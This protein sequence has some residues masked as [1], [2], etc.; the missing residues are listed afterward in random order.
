[1]P[2]VSPTNGSPVVVGSSAGS[3][4][5]TYATLAADAGS[6]LIGYARAEAGAASQAVE[7]KLREFWSVEDFGAV[8]DGVTDDL[9]AFNEAIA[10]MTAAG[11]HGVGGAYTRGRTLM[12]GAKN[13]L[14]SGTLHITRP[15]TLQG[16][17]GDDRF[18]AAVLSFPANTK[19][20][21][22]HDDHTLVDNEVSASWA[23]LRN[24]AI[25]GSAS[26]TVGTVNTSGLTVTWVSGT[27]FNV[28]T[29]PTHWG[30]LITILIG[31]ATYVVDEIADDEELTVHPWRTVVTATNNSAT[32][33]TGSAAPFQ[34]AW[35]GA[36][37]TINGEAHTIS[38][39]AVD[40]LSLTLN[41][42]YAEETTSE[43]QFILLGI[44]TQTGAVYRANVYHGVQS[45]VSCRLDGV[46]VTGFGGN[47]FH[48]D[49]EA[50]GLASQDTNAN[51]FAVHRS[52]AYFCH[53]HGFFARGVNSNNGTVTGCDFSNNKGAGVWEEGFL[54]N[55]YVG[56]HTAYNAQGAYIAPSVLG[57]NT[58]LSC[59]SE[60]GQPASRFGQNSQIM[61]GDHGAGIST[62]TEGLVLQ[63]GN[64]PHAADVSAIRF[65]RTL[66]ATRIGEDDGANTVAGFLGAN[67]DAKTAFGLSS[68]DESGWPTP[69][70]RLNYGWIATGWWSWIHNLQST[71]VPFMMS[72]EAADVGAGYLAIPFGFYLG[73]DT[74]RRFWGVGTAAPVAGAHIVGDIVWN[75]DPVAGGSAGWM[76]T[77]AGTP[78]DWEPFGGTLVLPVEANT[79]GV[80]APNVLLA[81]EVRK[82]LTNEGT[83]A[84]NY[85]TLPTAV[86]GLEYSFVVQDADGIRVTAAAG[87]TIRIAASVSGTAGHIDSTTIGDSV[88]LVAINDTEWVATNLVG[89]G[90]TAT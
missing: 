75:V 56:C 58:W 49:T 79:A 47:G 61:G 2:Y 38:A 43:G 15:L 24:V 33:T 48:F 82:V 46:F 30:G 76:C 90:W 8:G 53:G 68:G 67:D 44:G 77:G 20:V 41:S 39:V 84:A 54:G 45:Y 5:A 81:A 74:T 50:K 85:H 42:V 1:M 18:A 62:E 21:V 4:D 73:N 28:S 40:G 72:G 59:Y 27:K 80:G 63:A 87:D 65:R 11:Y 10:A 57:W 3:G 78:G 69:A 52:G 26:G 7:D 71:R 86:A 35:V 31:S 88:T 23:T 16:P 37:V 19:G 36:S 13:Y 17:A 55:H 89:A 66:G 83:T 29:G 34:E 32:V 9:A 22:L 6:S 25:Q 14:L 64:V 60:G 51:N 12:L 70:Y